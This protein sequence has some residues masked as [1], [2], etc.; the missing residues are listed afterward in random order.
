MPKET[1][2][3]T[4]QDVLKIIQVWYLGSKVLQKIEVVLNFYILKFAELL[5]GESCSGV[6]N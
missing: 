1:L 2:R 5:H 4:D 3:A 6:I